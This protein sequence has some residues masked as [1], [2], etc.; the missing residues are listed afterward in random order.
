MTAKDQGPNPAPG[1]VAQADPALEVAGLI[2]DAGGEPRCFWQPSMPDY[3]DHEWGLPVG[4][5]RR[6]YEKICLEGFQAGMAWITI[7]R[8]R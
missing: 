6:L 1:L 8:K 4:S 7:L 2:L 5:D 3:H